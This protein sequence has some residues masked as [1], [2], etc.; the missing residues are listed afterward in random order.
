[1]LLNPH[2]QPNPSKIEDSTQRPDLPETWQTSL[3]PLKNL[4]DILDSS[5]KVL[6][7]HAGTGLL[8]PLHIIFYPYTK[9]TLQRHQHG[10][11]MQ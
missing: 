9:P 8:T 7:K 3:F 1:M 2:I 6:R 10:R 5:S 11:R 4:I